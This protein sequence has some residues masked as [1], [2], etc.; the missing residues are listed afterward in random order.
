[1]IKTE[2]FISWSGESSRLVA[3]ALAN[4]LPDTL[5]FIECWMSDVDIGA[6]AQ[7]SSELKAH[8]DTCS[9]GIL[10]LTP[11]N[12]DSRWMLFEAG[13]LAKS[14]S[15]S[16]II[17]YLFKLKPTDVTYPLA[18]FQAA[19]T[20]KEGTL[21]LITSLNAASEQPMSDERVARL[22]DHWWNDLDARI[23]TIPMPARDVA[24]L[25]VATADRDDRALLEELLLL[26]RNMQ[27][28]AASPPPQSAPIPP[29][30][31]ASASS[32]RILLRSWLMRTPTHGHGD[33]ITKVNIPWEFPV[34][35]AASPDVPKWPPMLNADELRK[36][37]AD[38]LENYARIL[39]EAEKASMH[40][41]FDSHI[42]QLQELQRD[43]KAR[44]GS[45]K[46]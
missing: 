27:S 46:L 4:W 41:G 26:V 8:L 25:P 43:E 24:R 21:K 1:M 29:S 45:Q 44:R 30:A 39:D 28:Q 17:P 15:G 32:G 7:W 2:V 33:D 13:Y 38:E 3:R 12:L 22:L 42:K 35:D 11:D 6:G 5:Q 14:I 31:P 20:T 37:R 40:E 19:E 16:R 36:L 23:G 18:Q 34:A 10:C 9:F